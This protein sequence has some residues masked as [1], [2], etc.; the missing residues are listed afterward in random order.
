MNHINHLAVAAHSRFE[1]LRTRA[2]AESEQ[3]ELVEKVIITAGVA[4]MAIAAMAAISLLV[5]GKIAGIHL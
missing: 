4:L 2:E 5:S 1:E 3:G